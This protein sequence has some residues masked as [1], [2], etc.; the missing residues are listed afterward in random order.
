M[1]ESVVSPPSQGT[2]VLGVGVGVGIMAVA[3]REVNGLA[4]SQVPEASQGPEVSQ[5]SE[6]LSLGLEMV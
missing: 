2:V 6:N 4:A 5:G 3:K 1:N